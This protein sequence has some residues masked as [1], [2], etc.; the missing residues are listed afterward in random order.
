M[1]A[2]LKQ[3]YQG[4][5]YSILTDTELGSL[6]ANAYSALSAAEFNVADQGQVLRDLE[7]VLA[8]Q[9]ANRTEN[10]VAIYVVPSI[11]GTNY[12]DWDAGG[13][14]VNQAN[15][16]YYAGSFTVNDTEL[17]AV[18]AGVASVVIPWGG[19]FKIAV[20]NL[21]GQAFAATGNTVKGRRH[22]YQSQ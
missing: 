17:V 7:L 10:S 18:R 9:A 13:T 16:T 2:A 12:V 6:A 5:A 19:K 21:T 3:P 1:T 20:R 15:E 4:D 8:A 14:A 22:G 11:D